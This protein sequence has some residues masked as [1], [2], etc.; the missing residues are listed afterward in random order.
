MSARLSRHLMWKAQPPA[1][2]V[3]SFRLGAGEA[4]TPQ[5]ELA[6][7]ILTAP[8]ERAIYLLHIGAEVEHASMVQYLYAA[9]SLGGPHLTDPQHKASALEWRNK[10]LE[11]AREEMGHLATVENLLTLIGGPLSFE[12]EDFPVPP[13]LYPF[14]FTLEPLT[15]QSLGK[16]VLAEAPD[17]NALA[18]HGLAEEVAAIRKLVGVEDNLTVNRVGALYSAISQLFQAPNPPQEPQKVP[19]T[20][21]AS[22]DIQPSSIKYQVT[23]SEWGLGYQDIYISTAV[24]RTSAIDAIT[25]L[26]V[27]GEGPEIKNEKELR[28]SH[29]FKF[30]QIYRK[31]PAAKEW[32]PAKN[33]AINPTTDPA[34]PRSRRITHKL[35]CTWAQLANLRYRMLLMFLSHSFQIQAPDELYGRTPRGL[36]VT[37]TFGEMYN[38]RSIT[39]ILM[40]MPLGTNSNILAGPPFEMPY[41]LSLPSRD[42]DRWRLHRDLLLASQKYVEVLLG[43]NPGPHKTYLHG[44]HSANQRALEQVQTLIGG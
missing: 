14:P 23:P 43:E 27:Q 18:D 16:Y 13:D 1:Q 28:A 41:S 21:I 26:S 24:D 36:L 7:D 3:A 10:I 40:T 34:A 30:L 44:L 35:A 17:E 5:A 15:Q 22:G 25:K 33:V 6:L 32:V 8:R 37:W 31:F 4:V 2:G 29:F 19:P 11:I 20:F 12:R 39:E 38:L 42:A 9:Y